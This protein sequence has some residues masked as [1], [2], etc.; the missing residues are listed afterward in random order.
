MTLRL[1]TA[2]EADAGRIADIH[3]LAFGSNP[4]L[5]AHFPSPSVREDLRICIA[6]KALYDIRNSNIAVLIVRDQANEIIS[7][8]KWSLP[9]TSVEPHVEAPWI[10]PQGT[11]MLV[12]DEWTKKSEA[13]KSKTLGDAFC[14]RKKSIHSNWFDP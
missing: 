5:L 6:Q 4:L 9:V 3:M 8:A 1:A 13:A 7:F 12:L 2:T 14:Y 10:W 11:N